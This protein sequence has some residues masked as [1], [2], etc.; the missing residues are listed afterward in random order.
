MEGRPGGP[1]DRIVR[2]RLGRVAAAI[3]EERAVAGILRRPGRPV[4]LRHSRQIGIL[5]VGDRGVQRL[6][7]AGDIQ[8]DRVDHA[9][10][11]VGRLYAHGHIG[12]PVDRH[13]I[14]RG[15]RA[16]GR[17]L[18]LVEQ[19]LV[20]ALRRV[21][22]LQL[23]LVLPFR[24][25]GAQLDGKGLA[26]RRSRDGLGTAHRAAGQIARPVIQ[27]RLGIEPAEP[28]APRIGRG[29]VGLRRTGAGIGPGAAGS[30]RPVA[31]VHTG[32]QRLPFPLAVD[33]SQPFGEEDDRD[34]LGCLCLAG[35]AD[36]A[37]IV[38]HNAQIFGVRIVAIERDRRI[39]GLG[40]HLVF[41]AGILIDRRFAD[42]DVCIVQRHRA[43][44]QQIAQP[45]LIARHI[46]DRQPLQRRI[47]AMRADEGGERL[48]GRGAIAR[49]V[50]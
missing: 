28:V 23:D 35:A 16:Q 14:A 18:H 25:R 33:L 4:V 42:A 36:P 10:E 50:H 17:P 38:Q 26:G 20:I 21:R 27:V 43:E 15:D 11:L 5:I 9:I 46:L 8:I 12:E 7:N 48:V 30:G 39:A 34:Q 3:E 29:R 24:H 6:G 47:D 19:R 37:G 13:G 40:A 45:D 41:H 32:R 44:I 22:A 2:P 49:S 31:H 1:V